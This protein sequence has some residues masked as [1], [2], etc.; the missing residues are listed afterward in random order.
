LHATFSLF[1]VPV[2]SITPFFGSGGDA[3]AG[4]SSDKALSRSI[5]GEAIGGVSS[6]T[7]G[8]EQLLTGALTNIASG[9]RSQAV[10]GKAPALPGLQSLLPAVPLQLADGRMNA[11]IGSSSTVMNYNDGELQANLDFGFGYYNQL[12]GSGSVM[13]HA[14][15][16]A[17]IHDNLAV[18]VNGL[19]YDQR[20][21]LVLSAVW[22]V[23]DSGVRLKASGGYMWGR[24]RYSFPSG[25]ATVGLSQYS[26]AMSGSWFM[27]DSEEF[28]H[29]QAIGLSAWGAQARQNPLGDPVYFMRETATEFLVFLDP[30][31]LSEGRLIGASADAQLA[32]CQSLVTKGSIGYEQLRFPFSDGT[33]ELNSSVYC[34]LA[35]YWEPVSWIT[36]AADV[37]KGVSEDRIGI[38]AESGHWKVDTWYS[39]G[40]N[41]LLSDKGG[42][43]T[44][45]LFVPSAKNN[46]TL[47]RRMQPVRS[48][49]SSAMLGDALQRPVQMP[50]AFLAKVDPTAVRQVATISKTGVDNGAVVDSQGDITIVVGTGVPVITGVTRDGTSFSYAGI[51]ETTST[52]VIIHT[53]KLPDGVST[54]V[55]G[56]NATDNYEVTFITN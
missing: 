49:G 15:F 45:R 53:G 56:V 20:S 8:S 32:L 26:W 21:D 52:Q 28:R 31:Q 40:E 22:Q 14:G 3:C 47:A 51:I 41:G 16:A 4:G 30:L 7:S 9:M 35:M 33:R 1:L 17:M 25:D 48:S 2:L 36:L 5:T 12:R 10:A 27:N 24:Q 43:L 55:I 6:R 42:M 29:F 44:F 39:R 34:N 46:L 23:P 13:G 54:Y 50:Q 37:K 19:M 11:S 38:S 18:G